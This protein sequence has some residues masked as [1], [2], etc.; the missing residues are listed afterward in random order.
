MDKTRYESEDKD[1]Y[2]I[3]KPHYVINANRIQS[4]LI[5]QIPYIIQFSEG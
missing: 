3:R 4:N 5:L 1:I 2:I